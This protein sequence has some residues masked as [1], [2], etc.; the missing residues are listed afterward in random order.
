[1]VSGAINSFAF[2][3]PKEGSHIEYGGPFEFERD[4]GQVEVSLPLKELPGGDVTADNL[5][6][7][8]G[9][10]GVALADGEIKSS[11]IIS[12]ADIIG[13]EVI[14]RVDDGDYADP[15]KFDVPANPEVNDGE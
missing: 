4:G 3:D 1:M 12:T 7:R 2:L 9:D 14:V 15:S 8:D 5:T 13:E 10:I 11:G 6:E